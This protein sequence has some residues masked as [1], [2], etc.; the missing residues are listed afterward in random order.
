MAVGAE[1]TDWKIGER[2]V[3][4]HHVPCERDDCFFCARQD[5]SQCPVY[6]QT[7]TTAGFVPAGGGFAEY[8]RVM[9]WCAERGMVRIPDGVSFEEASFVEPLNTCLKGLR[10]AGVRQGDTVLVIGQG[11]IGLLFTLLAK[12]AG[13]TVATTDRFESRRALSR[14]LGA[15]AA[16]DPDT[17]DVPAALRLLSAGRGADAAIVAVPNTAV[18]AGAFAAV[19]PAGRVLLFA[20]TRLNDLLEIDAGAVCMQEKALLGSYSSD[21]RLQA[22]AAELIF[23]RRVDVRPLITHRFPLASIAEALALASHPQGGSL[24][25]LVTP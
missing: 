22:E 16:L 23:S 3:V 20:Q 17:E 25:V 14:Q 19:R 18:I 10:T 7:G 6:K 15:D 8:V 12:A 11:P 13:A 1:V 24:K 4:N 2:V 9:D 5:F 21:I